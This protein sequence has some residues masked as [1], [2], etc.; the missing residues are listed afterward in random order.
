MFVNIDTLQK[1]ITEKDYLFLMIR[2][3]FYFLNLFETTN[4]FTVELFVTFFVV[5][6]E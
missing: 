5:V 3:H 4:K 2:F 6:I 1:P